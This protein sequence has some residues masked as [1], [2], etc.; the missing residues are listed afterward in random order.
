MSCGRRK[1]LSIVITCIDEDRSLL[2]RHT[3][4]VQHIERNIAVHLWFANIKDNTER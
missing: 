1:A 3:G 4:N 2:V